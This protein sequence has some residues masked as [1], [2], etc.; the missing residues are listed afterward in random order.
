[1][2]YLLILLML[3]LVFATPA[4]AGLLNEYDSFKDF[5]NSLQVK[6]GVFYDAQASTWQNVYGASIYDFTRE[7][8]P[9]VSIEAAYMVQD[10]A[11]G[12]VL[13]NIP[14]LE[15]FG[16]SLPI[17][18]L[19]PRIGAGAGYDFRHHEPVYGLAMFGITLDF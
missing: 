13:L 1:M 7:D 19:R 4:H 8:I 5:V 15:A 16:I 18:D 9:I 11:L 3:L 12:L 10:T 2:K 14:G 17:G 6:H